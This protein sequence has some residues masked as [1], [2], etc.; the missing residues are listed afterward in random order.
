M[1]ESLGLP[2][3]TPRLRAARP[4]PQM[5]LEDDKEPSEDFYVDPPG[6]DE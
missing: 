6:P 3:E 4:P 5:E 2:N 1:L